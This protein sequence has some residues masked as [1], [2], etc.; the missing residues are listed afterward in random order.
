MI[1]G[2]Y[3]ITNGNSDERLVEQV[4]EAL[5]G[6]ARIVQYR[7]KYQP[8]DQQMEMIRQLL[9]VCQNAGV[10]LIVNDLPDVALRS[11][12]DGVHLGQDDMT[13]SEARKIMGR[14]KLIG[15]TCRTVEQAIMAEMQGAD[16]IGFG[17]IFPTE[18]KQDTEVVG[19]EAL[20]KVRK[21]V[22]IPVVAI[23]GMT[24]ANASLAIDA[25]ANS[26]AAYS[27]VMKD[28]DPMRAALEISLL[29]NRRKPL[30]RGR[31][32]TIAGSDSGGGAGIQAD[33]KTITLLGGYGAS[34]LTALTAQ[35]TTG[36]QAI[37]PVSKEFI[38]AQIESVLDDIPIDVVKTGMLFSS[39]IVAQVARLLAKRPL[40]SVVDPVIVAKGGATLLQE[41]AVDSI[42]THL[43][44]HTYLLTPNLPEAE[45]LTGHPVHTLDQMEKA[46]KHLQELGARN[47]LIKGGHMTGEAVDL[48]LAGDQVHHLNADRIDTPNTHGTGC[49]YSAAISAFLAQGLPLVQAV[50]TAK[51]FITE[52][53]RT[54]P[55]IGAGHG[56]VNHFAAAMSVMH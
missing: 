40:L 54:A 46:A 44:P 13:A 9:T 14:D 35:N 11:G 30:P 51:T 7:A 49:T 12:A 29:F 53:I 1:D 15:V 28:G 41:E 2:L 56:P 38:S 27:S 17:A 3:L 48:L 55:D 8:E 10:P 42:I 52:A 43:L 6:G 16:Y 25:G 31:V 36:V 34:V 32:L 26:V 5:Q 23:G 19:L 18:T 37:E 21:A 39:E 47:V 50:E 24:P 33:L 4:W 22:R 20:K 45:A